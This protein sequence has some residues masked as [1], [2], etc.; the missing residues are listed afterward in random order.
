MAFIVITSD[1]NFVYL[2]FN[3][4]AVE[5]TDA[6][7]KRSAVRSVCKLIEDKGVEVI[8]SDSNY[9]TLKAIYV[10]SIDGVT[11]NDNDELFNAL[12]ALM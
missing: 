11:I 7:V 1:T 12:K 8:W 6:K 5:W 9:F 2:Q 4:A 10:D 3:N